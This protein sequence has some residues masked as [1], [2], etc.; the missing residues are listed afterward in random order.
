MLRTGTSECLGRDTA[1]N[2]SHSF[3][4]FHKLSFSLI[5]EKKKI[6]RCP[7]QV[8]TTRS[9]GEWAA[10]R[11]GW[12]VRSGPAGLVNAV[13]MPTRGGGSRFAHGQR[14]GPWG[15]LQ[16]DRASRIL[17]GMVIGPDRSKAA[18]GQ[19]R[20]RNMRKSRCCRCVALCDL[21]THL[22]LRSF[23]HSFKKHPLTT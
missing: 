1:T 7:D 10:E 16:E 2:S 11:V 17:R 15:S 9:Q 12:R 21:F 23:T 5:G 13:T 14:P 20:Q 18:S 3:P 4:N 8:L 19:I 6:L 22:P